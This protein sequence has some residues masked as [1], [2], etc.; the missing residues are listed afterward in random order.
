M[1]NCFFLSDYTTPITTMG[2]WQCLPLSVVQLKGKYCWKAHCCNRVVDTFWHG[3]LK[4]LIA[5]TEAYKLLV[6]CSWHSIWIYQWDWNYFSVCHKLWKNRGASTIQV[7]AIY[8]LVTTICGMG[9]WWTLE[10]TA[11]SVLLMMNYSMHAI[12]ARSY[13]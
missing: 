13:L 5:V 8:I 11:P 12:I 3:P 1:C 4:D 10:T 2:C 6:C 7:I 9:S